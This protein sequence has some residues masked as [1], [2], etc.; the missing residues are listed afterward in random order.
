[1]IPRREG[2][3]VGEAAVRNTRSREILSARG[4]EYQFSQKIA[5]SSVPYSSKIERVGR[6]VSSTL[7]RSQGNEVSLCEDTDE[8]SVLD[9]RETADLP[10]HQHARRLG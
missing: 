3:I 8:V 9:H 2:N 1:M 6:R 7:A 10:L 4:I 5:D